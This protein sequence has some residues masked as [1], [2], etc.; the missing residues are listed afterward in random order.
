MSDKERQL[1]SF[2]ASMAGYLRVAKEED[3]P[4]EDIVET[5]NEKLDDFVDQKAL[6]K[7]EE[8]L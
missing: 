7:V 5:W 4:A 2:V 8:V 1:E 6:L 3:F